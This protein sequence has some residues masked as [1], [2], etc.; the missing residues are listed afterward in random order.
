M[1]CHT[2]VI[3]ELVQRGVQVNMDRY[4]DTKQELAQT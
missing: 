1:L 3:D 4:I 2:E